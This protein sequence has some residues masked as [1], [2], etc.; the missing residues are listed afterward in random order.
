MKFIAS[1]K[2]VE[3]ALEH[4]DASDTKRRTELE[5]LRDEIFYSK[6]QPQSIFERLPVEVQTEI[7]SLVMTSRK[8]NIQSLVLVCRT[9]KDLIYG[10]PILWR[11]LT[12]NFDWRTTQEM[13]DT[14]FERTTG[15]VRSLRVGYIP[16]TDRN[17]EIGRAHV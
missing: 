11:R 14:W 7:F 6:R 17:L 15:I 10:T 5:T 16:E 4:V 12:F 2:I 1:L 3:L 9:W 13:A 8:S